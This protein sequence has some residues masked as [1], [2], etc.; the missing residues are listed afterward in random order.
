MSETDK[1]GRAGT[2]HPP[3]SPMFE[4]P[5]RREMVKRLGTAA[6]VLA[7]SAILGR[8]AWDQGGF[9]AAAPPAAR[10]VRAS[11]LKDRPADLAELAIAKSKAGEP[12]P[13]A[14]QLVRRAVEAM[15]GMKRFVSRGDIVV[16]K[17]NIG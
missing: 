1:K 13:S 2:P 6:G 12:E 15:G 11:R 17:P 16:I 3:V 10:Q 14:D 9:A 8:L 5:S 7:G 4:R